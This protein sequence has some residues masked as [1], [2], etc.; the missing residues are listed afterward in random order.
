MLPAG[1]SLLNG[2]TTPFRNQIR[3]ILYKPIIAP[4]EQRNAQPMKHMFAATTINHGFTWINL[5]RHSRNQKRSPQKRR[6]H[7][8]ADLRGSNEL[9]GAALAHAAGPK[10]RP[11]PMH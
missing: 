4:V 8:D 7:W 3:M 10:A 1:I 2:F 11:I 5:A 9:L 6:E